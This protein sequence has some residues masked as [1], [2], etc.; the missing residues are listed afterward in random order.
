MM[1][2]INKVFKVFKQIKYLNKSIDD[3]FKIDNSK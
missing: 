2:P 3:L 1:K